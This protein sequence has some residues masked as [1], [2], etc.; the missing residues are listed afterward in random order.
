M[1]FLSASIPVPGREFYGTDD[2][3]A[4]REAVMAFT[5]VC[6]EK[7]LSFYFGGHPAITPLVW[8][9]AKDYLR[10]DFRNLIRIYQSSFFI[11]KTPKEVEYFNNVVWTSAKET[12][13]ESVDFM[14]E[15]MFKENFTTIAVFIGGM[16]GITDEYSKV[17]KYYPEALILPIATTGAASAKLYKD[18]GLNNQDLCDNYSYVSIFKKYLQA[19]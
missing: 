13:P 12:I 18:L 16:N 6:M 19:K 4:I 7:R 10:E 2:V 3:V 15:Q 14:R 8:E 11:G 17:Q 5:K 9:V 1:I